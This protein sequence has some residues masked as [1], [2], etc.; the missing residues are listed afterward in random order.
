MV[1]HTKAR[2]LD[3]HHLQQN[4]KCCGNVINFIR[5]T[6]CMF[7]WRFCTIGSRVIV[8]T[9]LWIVSAS[10]SLTITWGSQCVAM[11]AR[12]VIQ[13]ICAAVL[14]L[15]P[16]T[17]SAEFAPNFRAPYTIFL[18]FLDFIDDCSGHSRMR[19]TVYYS[20]V[21]VLTSLS[22][23]TWYV[24]FPLKDDLTFTVL[25]VIASV[26]FFMGIA[27]MMLQYSCCHENKENIRKCVPCNE[28]D[29]LRGKYTDIRP[30][31]NFYCCDT[32]CS[33][34]GCGT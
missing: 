27:S 30:T 26:L 20:L 6:L 19:A 25:W 16:G 22:M 9:L 34:C 31:T 7:L 3:K 32:C 10:Q 13:Y 28:I 12:A 11:H 1:A 29:F 17:L 8:F 4:R 21:F 2:T 15:V 24:A 33:G 14:V 5:G 18:N 23:I